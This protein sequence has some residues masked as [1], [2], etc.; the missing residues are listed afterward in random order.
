VRIAHSEA[1]AASAPT[2]FA[3]PP[4]PALIRRAPD[5]AATR[6]HTV[7]LTSVSDEHTLRSSSVPDGG[8]VAARSGDP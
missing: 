2:L 8:R 6:P 5:R 7:N 4:S 3:E 1:F